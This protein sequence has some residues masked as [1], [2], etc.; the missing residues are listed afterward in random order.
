LSVSHNET[1]SQAFYVCRGAN[2]NARSILRV[3]GKML[4]QA[5]RVTPT[6]LEKRSDLQAF[7]WLRRVS[8]LRLMYR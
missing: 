6:D 4:A 1:A 3:L 2:R 7:S 8:V 5:T